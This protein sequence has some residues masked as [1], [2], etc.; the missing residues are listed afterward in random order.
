[1]DKPQIKIKN[2]LKDLRMKGSKKRKKDP[3][4]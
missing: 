4:S 3:K 1:V 2:Q